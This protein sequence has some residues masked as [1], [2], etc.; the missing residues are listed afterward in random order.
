MAVAISVL[1]YG[2]I[3]DGSMAS[4]TGTDNTESFR[5]ALADGRPVYV[6]PGTYRIT[7]GLRVAAQQLFG[8]GPGL[9][10]LMQTSVNEPVLIAS[11]GGTRIADLRLTHF[12]LPPDTISVPDGVGIRCVRLGDMSVI[13]RVAIYN[14][15]SG[16]YSYE[17]LTEGESN[18]IYSV[19]MQNLR[20]ERF[21]HSAVYL[22]GSGAGNTGCVLQNIYAQN[23]S[24][25][26]TNVSSLYGYY[27]ETFTELSA[28]Q[29]N[30]EWGDYQKGIVIAE[31]QNTNLRSLHFERYRATLTHGSFI[32]IR[33]STSLNAVLSSIALKN[34]EFSADAASEYSIIRVEGRAFVFLQALSVEGSV[35]SGNPTLTAI[36]CRPDSHEMSIEAMGVRIIDH[37]FQE[38]DVRPTSARSVIRRFNNHPPSNAVP[39]E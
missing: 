21:R 30:I 8:A 39:L 26:G 23:R 19:Q 22:R 35:I 1:E 38:V 15:T 18:Y 25:D 24:A 29:L 33:G 4:G 7:A 34:C 27:F 32:D 11:S 12:S 3:P 31:S 2:A 9:S 28:T 17:S 16:V 5:R 37:S 20:I 36:V 13:E 14:C 6:P 10:T